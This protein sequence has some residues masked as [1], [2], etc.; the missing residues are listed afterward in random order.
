MKPIAQGCTAMAQ[1]GKCSPVIWFGPY[2]K[3]GERVYTESEIRKW[4]SECSEEMWR[5]GM[6]TEGGTDDKYRAMIALKLEELK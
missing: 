1:D 5:I 2:P 4:L 3:D 6:N